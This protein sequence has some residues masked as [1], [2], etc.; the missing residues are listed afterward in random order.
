MRKI[1]ALLCRLFSKKNYNTQKIVD[2][3]SSLLVCSKELAKKIEKL[4][5]ES[6]D[7]ELAYQQMIESL[8]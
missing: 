5:K 3:E 1:K 4:N 6:E 8:L 7:I 2:S